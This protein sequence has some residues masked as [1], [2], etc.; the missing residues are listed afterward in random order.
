MCVFDKVVAE[1]YL[2]CA[3]VIV[4]CLHPIGNGGFASVGDWLSASGKMKR[5]SKYSHNSLTVDMMHN[6]HKI[7]QSHTTKDEVEMFSYRNKSPD[8]THNA[9]L[10]VVRRNHKQCT[11]V[12]AAL[13][14]VNYNTFSSLFTCFVQ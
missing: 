2:D 1:F 13:K 12:I 9:M 11:R 3:Y 14:F 6:V 5:L 8:W 7:C 10:L 4:E